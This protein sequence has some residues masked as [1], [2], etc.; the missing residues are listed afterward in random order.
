VLEKSVEDPCWIVTGEH[1]ICGGASGAYIEKADQGTTT[2]TDPQFIGQMQNVTVAVGEDVTLSC[3]VDSLGPYLVSWMNGSAVIVVRKTVIT[4]NPRV[5]ATHDG[6]NTWNLTLKQVQEE[7]RGCYRCEINGGTK[8]QMSCVDVLVPHYYIITED[9]LSEEEMMG[10]MGDDDGS[11]FDGTQVAKV[12]E[13]K[14]STQSQVT[15]VVKVSTGIEKVP[16]KVA[17]ANKGGKPGLKLPEMEA[18]ELVSKN[19]KIW[20]LEARVKKLEGE[21]Q[22]WIEK[23]KSY[24]K[25]LERAKGYVNHAM[26]EKII[27]AFLKRQGFNWGQAK[28][29]F[30]GYKNPYT[31]WRASIL[32]KQLKERLKKKLQLIDSIHREVK[33]D[34][35]FSQ[36][37]FSN[38][39]AKCKNNDVPLSVS[40]YSSIFGDLW[41][42]KSALAEISH[43]STGFWNSADD[44][45]NPWIAFKMSRSYQVGAVVVDDRKDCCHHRFVNVKVTVGLSPDINDGANISCGTQSYQKDGVTTY[46]YDCPKGTS[47]QFVFVQKHAD[48]QM[49]KP[50]RSIHPYGWGDEYLA[51][52]HIRVVAN[53]CT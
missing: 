15:E 26:E 13:K 50:N 20:E 48:K 30:K 14:G 49:D 9:T 39:P 10:L 33:K 2:V 37:P 29:L 31:L 44:D 27:V 45:M 3:K 19:F 11:H 38:L 24:A 47:G 28:T 12:E 53:D 16:S 32:G 41:V 4:G 25:K 22:Q 40:N 5:T 42:P 43:T 51:V 6:Q 35:S 8:A 36:D 18:K 34:N 52:N 21:K 7:D 46:R 23:E 1:I 17:F